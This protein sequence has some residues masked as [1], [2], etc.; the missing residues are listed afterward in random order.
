ML[1]LSAKDVAE[2]PH[3]P[4]QNYAF[5]RVNEEDGTIDMN[6]YSLPFRLHENNDRKVV[7]QLPGERNGVTL[8]DY[9]NGNRLELT[10]P[11]AKDDFG[12]VA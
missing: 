5:Y 12:L 9:D 6:H 1:G 8:A 11:N 7:A 3:L 2:S 4:D 10:I